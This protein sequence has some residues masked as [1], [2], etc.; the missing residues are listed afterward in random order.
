VGRVV[1]QETRQKIS[2]ATRDRSGE[3]GG[4]EHRDRHGYIRVYQPE[5]PY[6]AGDG[7]VAKH[8][9][10]MERE[11]GRYLEPHEVVHH[12]NRVRDDNRLENLAVMDW[13]EHNRMHGMETGF[14]WREAGP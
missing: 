7:T 4:R 6:A 14:S 8:R 3:F 12:I 13:E 9:L 11:L 10:V 5:H 1:S 2:Q